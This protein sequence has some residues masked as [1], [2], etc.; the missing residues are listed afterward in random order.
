MSYQRTVTTAFNRELWNKQHVQGL[1]TGL[2][3]LENSVT[4]I[5][6]TVELDIKMS[7][8]WFNKS[9]AYMTE[10]PICLLLDTLCPLKQN[11]QEG[12]NGCHGFDNHTF[13]L[14]NRTGTMANL[15]W[16]KG[17]FQSWSQGHEAWFSGCSRGCG[18]NF[19]GQECEKHQLDVQK[20]IL[21]VWDAEGRDQSRAALYLFL[22]L[23]CTFCSLLTPLAH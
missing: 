3:N 7:R 6:G 14:L 20:L 17:L 8:H 5:Y 1:Y 21:R 12:W 23:V 11:L 15:G 9:E 18:G 13:G 4:F 2:Q 22:V 19:S 16:T 10:L